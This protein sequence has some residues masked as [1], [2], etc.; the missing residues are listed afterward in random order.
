MRLDD[1]RI[2]DLLLKNSYVSKDDIKAAEKYAKERNATVVD[3]LLKEELINKDLLGQAIAEFYKVNYADLNTNIPTREDVLKI[4]ADIGKKYRLVIA[5]QTTDSYTIATDNPQQKGLL[6]ALKDLFRNKKI[7]LAFSIPEDIDAS[8]VHYREPLETRFKK[9][10]ENSESVAPEVVVEII[11]DAIVDGASDIHFEPQEKD[12]LIRVRI[13]GVLREAARI[14]KKYYDN[15][16]NLIKVNAHM[17]IDEHNAAQDGSMRIVK[18]DR[19]VDMRVSV[20]P[21]LDGEKIT[22]RILSE[23]VSKFSL[24]DI[25]LSERDQDLFIEAGKKPFGMILVTGPTGS[26]KTS[27]LYSLIRI[28]NTPEVNVT[29]IEDPVEYKIKG[30]NHIQVNTQTELT[31][32]KGLR[33]IVRQDPDIILVGEIRDQETAEIAVNAA[34]TGHLLLSTFHANDAATSIPRLLDMGIESFLLAST[35][36]LV[37]AQRLVRKICLACRIS[38]KYTR[39]A[40]VKEHPFLDDYLSKKK[41][42]FTLYDT[43]PCKACPGGGFQGRTAIFEF[44]KVTREMRDLI[45]QDP[46]TNEILDLAKKQGFV[47]MFEDGLDKVFNGITTLDELLRVAKPPETHA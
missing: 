24:S 9:I 1:K 13:D 38:R 5:N 2:R 43:K 45:L 10:L 41:K 46:S 16:L 30:V 11:D 33:S 12:V 23:Y 34:L 40:L 36:E 18:G 7:T 27:S 44:I 3:Y 15:I 32:A 37:V 22:V 29:T 47:T 25:G 4:P 19:R 31:F 17:R 21:T 20:M 35:L 8:L 39:A 26:G 28:L 6:P 42:E 14:G